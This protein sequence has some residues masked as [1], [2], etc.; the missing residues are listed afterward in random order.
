MQII[1]INNHSVL[2]MKLA[3]KFIKALTA[4]TIADVANY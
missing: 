4:Q 2:Y 3:A 1:E